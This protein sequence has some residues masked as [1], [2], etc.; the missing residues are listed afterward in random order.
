LTYPLYII[1]TL[2]PVFWLQ[3]VVWKSTFFKHGDD[4]N[5]LTLCLT[6]LTCT[7]CV[8]VG[9]VHPFISHEGP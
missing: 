3:T 6:T 1:V 9:R 8:Y 7:E 4:A 2:I 5:L